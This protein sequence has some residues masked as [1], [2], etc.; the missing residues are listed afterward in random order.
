MNSIKIL[1]QSSP[2]AAELAF[3]EIHH[4]A[5]NMKRKLQTTMHIGCGV[6]WN[7]FGKSIG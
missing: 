3:N 6:G 2:S 4:I 5:R 7:P 1:S